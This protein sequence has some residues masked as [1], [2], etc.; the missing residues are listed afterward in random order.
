MPGQAKMG[1]IHKLDSDMNYHSAWKI[2]LCA[3]VGAWVVTGLVSTAGAGEK[4]S[5]DRKKLLIIAGRQSHGPGDHEFNAGCML[6][7]KGLQESTP[8]LDVDLHKGGW[9]E[10]DT[11]FEGADAVFFYMDGGAGHPAIQPERLKL[12]SELMARGVG[13]GC[14]HYAVEVP[15][16]DPG[17]AWKNWIGG[18]YEHLFSCNP[19]WSPEFQTFPEHAIA[20]G[21]GPFS[22]R[23]EWYMN[24][25]FRP[26]MSG[27]VPILEARPS[28]KVR[29]GPY[30]YPRGPYKHIV[31]NSGRS[32][33]MMWAV[34]RE[35]GGRG[36]GFTGGHVHRN[37]GEP[38]FRKVMLNALLWISH[39]DV[40]AD[41]VHTVV[42]DEDLKLNLDPK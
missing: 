12:L 25:R 19:F 40:P 5:A 14:A 21:V 38:N 37:W 15:A 27:V 30:V 34:E 36:F 17:E 8:E 32:E 16:G 41:G 4:S 1:A 35:D 28:D 24:M 6:L 26:E 39:V 7:K 10:S 33:V 13:M 42:T 20:S 9:P 18:H 29:Q 31:D 23:D 11:A 22:I 2:L 3:T